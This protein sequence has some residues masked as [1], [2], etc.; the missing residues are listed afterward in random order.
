M[1]FYD[2]FVFDKTEIQTKCFCWPVF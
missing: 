1:C 2:S